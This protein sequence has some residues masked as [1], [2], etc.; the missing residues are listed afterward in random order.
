MEPM[1]NFRSLAAMIGDEEKND[2]ASHVEHHDSLG[3]LNVL[4]AEDEH[5]TQAS[6]LPPTEGSEN[7]HQEGNHDVKGDAEGEMRGVRQSPLSTGRD[8]TD[9]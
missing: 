3:A 1:F 2:G 7:G 4:E 8:V 5:A 6:F 9:S